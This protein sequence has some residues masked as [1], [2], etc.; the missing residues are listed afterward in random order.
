MKVHIE[1]NIYLESDDRQFIIKEYTGKTDKN[2]TE[3]FI[4]HGYFSS[5]KSALK[6]LVK[7]KIKEST[8]TT[9]KEL[10]DDINKIHLY[11]ESKIKM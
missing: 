1:K 6:H 10:I 2:G 3:L 9:L 4:T 8:A 5:I 11:I 7:M